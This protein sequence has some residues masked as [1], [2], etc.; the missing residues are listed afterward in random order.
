MRLRKID[1]VSWDSEVSRQHGIKSL[2]ALALYD[3]TSL[4]SE[5]TRAVMAHLFKN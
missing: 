3:G 4:V 2:P 5:D 1:V